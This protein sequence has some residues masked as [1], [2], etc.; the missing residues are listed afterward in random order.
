MMKKKFVRLLWLPVLLLAVSFQPLY[1]DSPALEYL[2]TSLASVQQVL[3]DPKLAGDAHLFQRR[4]LVRTV[5]QQLF[6]F[7]EMSRRSLGANARRYKD[8]VGEFTP[9]FVDFLE[10]TYMGT[11]EKNGDAK[12]QY[13]REIIDGENAQINTKTRLKDGS[14]YTVD[15]KLYLTPVGWRAYDVIV[16]GISLVNSYRSQFD[17]VL[18]KKSFDALL[19]DLREKKERF[20]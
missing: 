10:H 5:L 12:I 8:R 9:L 11:L 7:Q 19:Q 13:V 18:N 17:R 15:Y 3:G 1:A 2:K 16:E 20:N 6:D 4:K 14:E